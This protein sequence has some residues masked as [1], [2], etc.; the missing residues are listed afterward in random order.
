[1]GQIEAYNDS[2]SELGPRLECPPWGYFQGTQARVDVIS[3]VCG[4]L[5]FFCLKPLP[6]G[7]G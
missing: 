6:I 3:H 4:I 2:N 1:M 7:G 5:I